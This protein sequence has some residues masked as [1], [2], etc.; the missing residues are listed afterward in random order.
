[1]PKRASKGITLVELVAMLA[2][3]GVV[4]AGIV[5]ALWCTPNRA[6]RDH[7]ADQDRL[8]DAVDRYYDEI[9]TI[10]D[11]DG[12]TA[13]GFS[14]PTYMVNT[15]GETVTV[16]GEENQTAAPSG[17]DEIPPMARWT[18]TKGGSWINVSLLIQAGFLSDVPDSCHWSNTFADG[19]LSGTT[20]TM[21]PKDWTPIYYQDSAGYGTY[22]WYV[23][24]NGK[25][26]SQPTF[27]DAGRVY[28]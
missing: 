4:I 12:R 16:T 17:A 8:Q 10:T 24:A 26:Q 28:P 22:A 18:G 9:H 3:I 23:D 1:M 7:K 25:V 15:N 14:F 19:T 11:R 20:V 5:P 13:S 6:E 21:A 2:V 27:T